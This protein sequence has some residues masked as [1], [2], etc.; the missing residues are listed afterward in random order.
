MPIYEY[1]CEVGHK[2]EKREGFNGDTITMCP[3]CATTA[4]RIIHVP[5]VHYK[6][7]GFYTTD[8]GRSSSY[9]SESEKDSGSDSSATNAEGDSSKEPAKPSKKSSSSEKSAS[10]SKVVSKEKD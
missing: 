8:H 7:S 1:A 2:F 4:K 6:G 10:T 5:T 3:E 9:S